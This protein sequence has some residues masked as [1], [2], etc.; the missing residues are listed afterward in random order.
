MTN[1]FIPYEQYKDLLGS[2]GWTKARTK[3]CQAFAEDFDFFPDN[4]DFHEDGTVRQDVGDFPVRAFVCL[5]QVEHFQ[6]EN[7]RTVAEKI[8]A[9]YLKNSY[10]VEGWTIS[11]PPAFLKTPTVWGD[12]LGMSKAH[13]LCKALYADKDGQLP[14]NFG[15]ENPLIIQS[16]FP[17][18]SLSFPRARALMVNDPLYL[19]RQAHHELNLFGDDSDEDEDE[20]MIEQVN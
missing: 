15:Q 1:S 9:D 19:T 2:V 5:M 12:V 14:N 13:D 6:D 16:F 3:P 4:F 8:L 7:W 17:E 10:R 11:V 20:S 18:H